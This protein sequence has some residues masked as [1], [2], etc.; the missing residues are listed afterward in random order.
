MPNDL[1]DDPGAFIFQVSDISH[2][3]KKLTNHVWKSDVRMH[4]SLPLALPLESL[5]QPNS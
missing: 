1:E 3:I 4:A 5:P 2:L